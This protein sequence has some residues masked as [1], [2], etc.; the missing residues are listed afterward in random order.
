[1]GCK[2]K[3]GGSMN[4]RII[5]ATSDG[6]V[7]VRREERAW[8]VVERFL[9]GN[10]IISVAACKGLLLAGTRA[11]VWR[12]Q[13]DGANW[14]E[15]NE[16]LSI[17]HIRWLACHAGEESYQLAG[18]EPAGIFVSRDGGTT[19]ERRLEVDDLRRQHGW[20]LPYSPAA[21]CVR[22]FALNGERIYAAVEVGGV[23]R[24]NDSGNT[25][26]LV[27]GSRGD[28]YYVPPS[29]FIHPDVHSVT[30]HPSSNDFVYAPTG[31][32]FFRTQDGGATWQIHYRCYCRAVWVDPK[33]A[34]HM[35]LGPADG[36]DRNGRIEESR[37]GGKTWQFASDGL[38]APWRRH[39]VERF[40]QVDNIILAVLSNGELIASSLEILSWEYILPEVS[41]V[42]AVAIVD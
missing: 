21:G 3:F 23:L 1:L 5:V 42:T 6:L 16:G 38:Q 34:D 9:E 31:G 33:D 26:A 8:K 13:D 10:T 19:W 32:G 40:I 18:T 12:S 36:V 20:Y 15:A 28:P 14:E 2:M 41:G 7:V 25:W 24:S 37:D 22:G 30:G 29:V 11:G 4:G 17:K 35:L 39:M 27:S